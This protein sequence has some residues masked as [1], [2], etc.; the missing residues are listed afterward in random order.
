MRQN[1][2]PNKIHK[3][4]TNKSQP[5]PKNHPKNHPKLFGSRP[6]PRFDLTAPSAASHPLPP[7]VGWLRLAPGCS[8]RP[9]T[10]GTLGGWGEIMSQGNTKMGRHLLC[11]WRICS[12][13][14]IYYDNLINLGRNLWFH[15][16]RICTTHMM[17]GSWWFP[18]NWHTY[19]WMP[20]VMP[21]QTGKELE[22]SDVFKATNFFLQVECPALV[23]CPLAKLKRFGASTH[24]DPWHWTFAMV[25]VHDQWL[26]TSG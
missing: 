20:T 10:P 14:V 21:S 11:G 26:V 15:G 3:K 19:S 24:R 22:K 12:T 1:S 9:G 23:R 5:S 25:M 2:L 18:L 16:S 6:G 4:I 13:N 17:S 8:Q 7:S